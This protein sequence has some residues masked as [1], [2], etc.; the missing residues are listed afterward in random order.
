M[1]I[2]WDE[3]RPKTAEYAWF[4]IAALLFIWGGDE[5][6]FFWAAIAIGMYCR[7]RRE[8]REGSTRYISSSGA[9]WFAIVMSV[10]NGLHSM[11]EMERTR[12]LWRGIDAACGD[13]SSYQ[14]ELINEARSAASDYSIYPDG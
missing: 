3:L 7:Y 4:A 8:E 6:Q 9:L 12:I 10:L 2:D 11:Q 1:S 13:Y 5:R 14:C